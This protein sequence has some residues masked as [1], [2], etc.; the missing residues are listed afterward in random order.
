MLDVNYKINIKLYPGMTK[1]TK[2]Q[3]NVHIDKFIDHQINF[4]YHSVN[5]PTQNQIS[6]L[7]DNIQKLI[8]LEY[9]R[10]NEEI[11]KLSTKPINIQRNKKYLT[12]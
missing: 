3:L 9:K 5:D 10:L 12:I 11:S 4:F 6:I 7:H 1:L 2:K 8:I